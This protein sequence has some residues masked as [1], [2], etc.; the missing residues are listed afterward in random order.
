MCALAAAHLH[1]V[2]LIVGTCARAALSLLAAPPPKLSQAGRPGEGLR[3]ACRGC[4]PPPA[5]AAKCRRPA[6][7]CVVASKACDKFRSCGR[8]CFCPGARSRQLD[9]GGDDCTSV[10]PHSSPAMSMF[11]RKKGSEP[12]FYATVA[13]GL[14]KIYKGKLLPLEEVE[15]N[16]EADG[17]TNVFRLTTSMSLSL[18][19]SMNPTLMPDR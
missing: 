19:P 14:K 9:I 18:P 5:K 13:D 17:L 15:S 12:Q 2:H 7:D 10:P 11:K 6:C 8:R 4:Q 1:H 3:F 16:I